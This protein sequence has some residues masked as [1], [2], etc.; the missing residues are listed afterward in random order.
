MPDLNLPFLTVTEDDLVRIKHL[1][2]RCAHRP[3][4]PLSGISPEKAA[5]A[6][7]H[8]VEYLLADRISEGIGAGGWG[9]SDRLYMSRLYGPEE[10]ANVH[11]SVMTTVV[12]VQALHD[13]LLRMEDS[14]IRFG[15]REPRNLFEFITNGLDAYVKERWDARR[16]HGGVLTPGREGDLALVPRYRHTAWLFRLWHLLPKYRERMQLTAMNL[17]QEFDFVK[18]TGEKVATDVAAHSAISI[19]EGSPLCDSLGGGIPA[20]VKYLKHVLE[21]QIESKF[22]RE[23]QGWTSGNISE[24]GRQLYTLFVC[25]EMAC[26]YSQPQEA[27]VE[28]MHAALQATMRGQWHP[29]KGGGYRLS[30]AERAT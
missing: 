28:Q 23:Q 26:M 3:T 17:L 29:P 7:V 15:R 4:N 12:V 19:L 20:R 5:L 16:G 11:E 13:C 22:S 14:G 27:L 8:A 21:G 18:W 2:Q 10:A 9:V 24:G 25:I 1:F 30:L 6:L